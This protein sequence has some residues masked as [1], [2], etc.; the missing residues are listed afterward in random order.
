MDDR[1]F[2]NSSQVNSGNEP[3]DLVPSAKS[4]VWSSVVA[5]ITV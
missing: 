2:N 1:T 5:R 4:A 3:S